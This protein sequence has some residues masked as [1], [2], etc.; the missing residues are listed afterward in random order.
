[1]HYGSDIMTGNTVAEKSTQV[2][3]H[4]ILLCCEKLLYTL[5]A[6]FRTAVSSSP[7]TSLW[8]AVGGSDDPRS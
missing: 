8:A 7:R 1:M 2:Y 4:F 3:S 5:T 6:D